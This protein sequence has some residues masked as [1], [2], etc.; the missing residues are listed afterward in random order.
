MRLFGRESAVRP[1]GTRAALALGT[2]IPSVCGA[3]VIG[4]MASLG[5]PTAGALEDPSVLR[6]NIV[7][8]IA[9]SVLSIPPAEPEMA[10]P[11]VN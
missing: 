8:A 11:S 2:L 6:T 4:V 9:F 1:A 5:L 10:S 7:A 3:A